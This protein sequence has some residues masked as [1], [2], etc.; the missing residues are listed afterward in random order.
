VTQDHDLITCLDNVPTLI[1]RSFHYFSKDIESM[2]VVHR[3]TNDTPVCGLRRPKNLVY[4]R[5]HEQ[6]VVGPMNASFLA[7]EINLDRTRVAITTSLLLP[8]SFA[9]SQ[10][11]R[12]YAWAKFAARDP[13]LPS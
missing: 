10:I 8:V 4:P 6:T 3:S 9:Q 5:A 12:C 1:D 13:R 7:R 2:D 11:Y